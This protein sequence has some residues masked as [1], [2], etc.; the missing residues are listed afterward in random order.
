MNQNLQES[1][2]LSLIIPALNESA[3]IVQNIDEIASWMKTSQ[4]SAIPFEIV[5]V[6]DGSTDNMNQ[7]LHEAM[8]TR[9]WLVVV[10]HEQNMGRGRA[11]RTRFEKSQGEYVICMDA[12]LS[13]GPEHI[14]KLLLPL[15]NN[16]ADVTL[17][18]PYHRDG[19]VE[20]VPAQRAF[21]SRMGNKILG[22]GFNNEF[23][24]VTCVT[25]GFRRCVLQ[26]LDLVNNGKE[27]HL[28][29]IQKTKLLG[30]RILEIPA[31]LIWRDKKR[32]AKQKSLLPE[33]A[34]FKMRKTVLSHL[35][36]NFLTNPGI[37]LLIP[38]L[39]LLAIILSGVGMIGS[40]LIY[41]LGHIKEPVFQI[42][43]QTLMDGQLSLTIVLFSF[44]MLMIFI[45]F[46]FLSA[47]SK[48]YYE[49]I[50]T[51]LLRLNSKINQ[52]KD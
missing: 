50:Y 40:A 13:Y 15:V 37:L 38:M 33:I 12:D 9:P 52:F 42:I 6:D 17:A 28:E 30:Y 16:E 10:K 46:Y 1:P 35:V 45:V 41:N 3:I 48:K 51:S 43:R 23:A 27:L 49:D 20:N 39:L 4:F 21:L 26:N 8:L 11:I 34:I 24:T 25:R 47:Q 29:I 36:F 44:V 18:S 22:L 14:E 31:S 2:M 19:K 32:H 7:L 5:I